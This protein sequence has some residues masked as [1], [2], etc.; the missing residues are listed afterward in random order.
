MIDIG[1]IFNV[2]ILIAVGCPDY[3]QPKNTWLQREEGIVVVGCD[4]NDKTWRLECIG[5]SWQGTV[6]QCPQG[7]GAQPMVSSLLLASY[8]QLDFH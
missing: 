7:K 2:Y 5:N 8:L 3:M 1:L 6:G 4:Q